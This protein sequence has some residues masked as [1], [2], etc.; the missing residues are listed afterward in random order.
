MI[1]TKA[2]TF[3]M[4]KKVTPTFEFDPL[5]VMTFCA[6]E[7]DKAKNGEFDPSVAALEE[8]FY[9]KY[10]KKM[11]LATTSEVL[12][13]ASYGVMQVMGLCLREDGYFNW[14]FDQLSPDEKNFF[15]NPDMPFAIDSALNNFVVNLEWMIHWGCVHLDKKRHEAHND[16]KKMVL[17]WN[18]G[19][20]PAYY[21]EWLEKYEAVKKEFGS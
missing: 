8:G 6:Q 9:W 11:N 18:G 5:V 17:L 3:E 15:K 21:D 16:L 14:W 1:F 12:L 13:A 7:A 4:C 20:R 2:Q 10:T 19:G